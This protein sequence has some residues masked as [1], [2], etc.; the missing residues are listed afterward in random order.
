MKVARTNHGSTKVSLV[1]SADQY[2]LTPIK[3]HTL[4]HFVDKV[5]VPGFRP[6]TAPV[7]L[8]ERYVNPQ[9]LNDEFI[10]H[11]LNQLYGKAI[12]EEK[13]RP[14]S[15]P[16]VKLKK[17]VPYTDLEFEVDVE[18]I[19]QIKLPDYTKTKLAKKAAS[20][21]PD[22][23]DSVVKNLQQRAAKRKTVDGAAKTGDEAVID[24]SGTDKSGKPIENTEGKAVAV[25]IG[26]KTLIP[27]FEDNLVGLKAGAK[28]EFELT[29]PADYGV[30][31]IQGKLVR[32]SVEAKKVSEIEELKLD[33]AFAAKVGPF[34]NL[35]EL[36]NDIK[37][38]LTAEKQAQLDR[39]YANEL[40][41][42]ITEKADIK[43]PAGLVEEQVMAA[44]ESEKK[45][46]LGRGQTWSEHLAEEAI[47]E[48]Q[49]RTRQRPEAEQRVK[50]S[51][52]LSE[53]AEKENIEVTEE[54]LNNY[55]ELLKKQ[56][57]D[58]QMQAELDKPENKRELASRLMT[59]K[60]VAKLVEYA[61]K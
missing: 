14:A 40:V 33:D 1:V 3:N 35:T 37:K 52:V 60:T 55:V 44:E 23:V 51:L 45:N 48:E 59:E 61:S 30:K 18:V 53:I 47:T 19:G 4:T 22:E 34:K 46:L 36:K 25:I 2:D 38:Q 28:K 27:G 58:E 24:F 5:R 26:S 21:T 10:E 8:V 12:D 42:K 41:G 16:E 17:F 9:S 49:H 54:E 32:F 11:A 6:G 39:E 56:Y 43:V 15:R 31:K 29:F 20:V 57:Q 13:I 50:A 7:A